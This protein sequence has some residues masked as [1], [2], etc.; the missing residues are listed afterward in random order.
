MASVSARKLRQ[1]PADKCHSSRMF[2]F[3]RGWHHGYEPFKSLGVDTFIIVSPGGNTLCTC[4]PELNSQVFRGSEFGK[5]VELLKV[6]NI[7]GP[8]MTGTEGEETRLYR[9]I[10]AP[11]FG[12]RTMQKV[13]HKSIQGS[14]ALLKVLT[15]YRS[16]NYIED[17]RSVTARMTL[18]LLCQICLEQE[19]DCLQELQLVGQIPSNHSLTYGQ[20][21]Q[22]VLE[23]MPILSA[24]PHYVLS[25]SIVST[26]PLSSS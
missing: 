8:T 12:D 18:H 11:F 15:S 1:H 23:H 21:L 22:I 13:W 5:P 2:V 3:T 4:D 24:F 16:R 7:F 26:P 14:A 25:I 6:L 9:K 20:A 10:T 17:L 19:A